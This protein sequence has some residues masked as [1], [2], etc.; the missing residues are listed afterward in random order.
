MWFMCCCRDTE[1]SC[2]RY[3]FVQQQC[4]SALGAL[5]TPCTDGS[6]R[7]PSQCHTSCDC[8]RQ[9]TRHGS[10][11]DVWVA[12]ETFAV[13]VYVKS[14]MFARDLSAWG[15]E[16]RALLIEAAVKLDGG[17][18][19]TWSLTKRFFI[20]FFYASLRLVACASKWIGVSFRLFQSSYFR[21]GV[22]YKRQYLFLWR[23]AL[24]EQRRWLGQQLNCLRSP[25][26][27]SSRLIT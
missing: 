16:P 18:G 6:R 24:M 26:C 2:R 19:D 13:H 17:T 5:L 12:T 22:V 27:F 23:R 21:R 4:L 14:Q 11:R 9:I 8:Q 1:L 10:W 25:G 3:L 20:L 7:V 15:N